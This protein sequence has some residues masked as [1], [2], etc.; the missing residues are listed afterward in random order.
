MHIGTCVNLVQFLRHYFQ[1][2]RSMKHSLYSLTG[3]EVIIGV[4]NGGWGIGWDTL[5]AVELWEQRSVNP[6]S[7]SAASFSS[8]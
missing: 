6:V 5:V 4:E 3:S 7:H 1:L 8:D 2:L